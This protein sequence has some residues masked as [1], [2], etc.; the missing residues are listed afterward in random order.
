MEVELFAVLLRDTK[1]GELAQAE[2]CGAEKSAVAA[3][4]ATP[5]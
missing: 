4:A 5:P 2:T 1:L 3:A